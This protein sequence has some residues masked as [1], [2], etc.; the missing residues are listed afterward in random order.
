MKK[1]KNIFLII[2]TSQFLISCAVTRGMWSDSRAGGDT[3]SSFFVDHERNRVVLIGD[4]RDKNGTDHYSIYEPTGKLVKIFELA[5]KAADKND[6]T[7]IN[8]MKVESYGSSVKGDTYFAFNTSKLS[9]EEREFL[10]KSK[11][12]K[13]NKKISG[14]FSINF[15]LT[16]SNPYFLITQTTRYP[17]SQE[18]VKNF[19]KPN[20]KPSENQDCI[21]ITKFAE[22]WQGTIWNRFT[23]SDK[24]IRVV[25]TPFTLAI[26]ILL[27]P[28]YLIGVIG[29]G[30]GSN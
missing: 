15:P 25:A 29:M 23:P 18:Q 3:I 9:S 22:P 12:T 17:S 16:N 8:L 4:E 11:V 27:T 20:T 19:C 10:D 7:T 21:E 30:V 13:N 6:K 1:L 5:Q 24:A 14:F 26:D 2:I 28:L